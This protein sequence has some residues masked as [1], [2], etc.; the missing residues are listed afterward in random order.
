MAFR[1]VGETELKGLPEPVTVYDIPW[2]SASVSE[3][4][5]LP[6]ALRSG[7]T[8]FPFSGRDE[9]GAAL[10]DGSDRPCSRS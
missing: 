3:A 7:P 1:L 8:E 2:R 10:A 5:P 6:G 9:E 4:A